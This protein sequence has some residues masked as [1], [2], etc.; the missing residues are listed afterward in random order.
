MIQNNMSVILVAALGWKDMI[1]KGR[2]KL[3]GHVE[4]IKMI[5]IWSSSV[6]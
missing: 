5:V 1:R 2:L 3:F 4:C 6:S